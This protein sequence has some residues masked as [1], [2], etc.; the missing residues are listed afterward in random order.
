MLGW[1]VQDDNN[2][3]IGQQHPSFHFTSMFHF[4]NITK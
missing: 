3:S 4:I 2:P 1:R